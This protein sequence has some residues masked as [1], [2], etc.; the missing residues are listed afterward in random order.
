MTPDEMIDVIQAAKDGE[1]IEARLD[2][3]DNEQWRNSDDPVWN[4]AR[5]EYRRKPK[6]REWWANEYGNGRPCMHGTLR[7]ANAHA[8]CNRIETIH[9]IEVLEE[10]TPKPEGTEQ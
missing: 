10:T 6:P 4:F 9:V 2:V 1:R 7:D 8:T 3:H 5:Y